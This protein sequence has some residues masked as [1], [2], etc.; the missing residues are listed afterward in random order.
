MALAEWLSSIPRAA[1]DNRNFD[2]VA[3]SLTESQQQRLLD[4]RS[5]KWLP[6][7][8]SF[9]EFKLI[10]THPEDKGVYLT[11]APAKAGFHVKWDLILDWDEEDLS[12]DDGPAFLK[13]IDSMI[14]ECMTTKKNIDIRDQITEILDEIDPVKYP[15]ILESLE[16][17]A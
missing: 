14:E 8:S 16:Q 2:K 1:L 3:D 15:E 12:C 5:T 11:L 6:S 10:L 4:V 9:H 17:Y 13:K 7:V